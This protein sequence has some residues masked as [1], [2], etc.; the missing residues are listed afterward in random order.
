MNAHDEHS[1][2]PATFQAFNSTGLDEGIAFEARDHQPGTGNRL[3]REL[4]ILFEIRHYANNPQKTAQTALVSAIVILSLVLVMVIIYLIWDRATRCPHLTGKPQ[5]DIEQGDVKQDKHPNTPDTIVDIT[6]PCHDP[7]SRDLPAGH[8]VDQSYHKDMPFKIYVSPPSDD[9]P[10]SPSEHSDAPSTPPSM[11]TPE[12]QEEFV[13][14]GMSVGN[15]LRSQLMVRECTGLP[16]RSA[17]SSVWEFLVHRH[18][19]QPMR[20]LCQLTRALDSSV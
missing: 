9:E 17:E 10:M 18:R 8:L 4:R 12:G 19:R 5:H 13:Y 1:A 2:T 15:R 11:G 3:D 7:M 14:S 20:E 6:G 16:P